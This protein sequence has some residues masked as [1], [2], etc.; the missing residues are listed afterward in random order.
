MME[1]A[2]ACQASR[3]FLTG[4]EMGIFSVLGDEK[5]TPA[6]VAEAIGADRRG[7]DRLL[8]ALCALELLTKSVDRYANAPVAAKYLV[9]GKPDYMSG[10]M[11]AVHLWDSWT[12]LTKAVRNGGTVT[13]GPINESGQEWLEAFIGAMHARAA[14]E[15]PFVVSKIDLTGVSH[16]LDVGGGSGAFSMSFVRAKDD[17]T[18]TIFDLPNVLPLTQKYIEQAGF[19]E[20][21]STVPGNYNEDELGTGF[22]LAFLSAIIHVN[23][24]DQNQALVD[25]VSRALNSGGRIVISD[26]IM[27]DNR[28]EPTD[29]ALFAL[30]MLTATPDGDTYT[31]S[32]IKGWMQLAGISFTKRIELRRGLSL[33][34]GTKR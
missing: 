1:L 7:T 10:L 13:K 33:M 34:I 15:A 26:F 28:F 29:G 32:E 3:V 20:R 6:E 11:H 9:K 5:K 25:K 19:S 2:R 30:N 17:L 8:N 21:I 18:A 16:L 14:K 22:D 27:E 23:S 4:Y 12:T 31:E 24:F